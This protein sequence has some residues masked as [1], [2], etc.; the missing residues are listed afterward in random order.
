MAAD[1]FWWQNSSASEEDKRLLP[2]A[3]KNKGPILEVLS[4]LLPSNG[5]ILEIASGTGQHMAHFAAALPGSLTWQPS[6]L[7]DEFFLSIKAHCKAFSN[8]KEPVILDASSSKWPVQGPVAAVIVAN[9]THIAPWEATLGL[10]SGSSRLLLPGGLLCIYGPFKLD[11][12]FTTQSN[13]E[14]NNQLGATNPSW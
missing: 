13:Q 6:D 3:E 12:Q 4:R 8:V 9:L 2:A 1:S 10:I 11:G 7:S 5:T 14:F